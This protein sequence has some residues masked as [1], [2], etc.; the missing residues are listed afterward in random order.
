[1]ECGYCWILCDTR[2]YMHGFTPMGGKELRQRNSRTSRSGL[3]GASWVSKPMR[4]WKPSSGVRRV[5]GQDHL[6]TRKTIRGP[7]ERIKW[8]SRNY[9]NLLQ[10]LR[11]TGWRSWLP[12]GIRWDLHQNNRPS[13]LF[14]NTARHHL[15]GPTRNAEKAYKHIRS[16]CKQLKKSCGMDTVVLTFHKDEKGSVEVNSWVFIDFS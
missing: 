14:P 1:M 16:F 8:S 15:T 12:Y 7:S 2:D 6:P 3:A 9:G 5:V 11:K 4:S 10:L 13:E